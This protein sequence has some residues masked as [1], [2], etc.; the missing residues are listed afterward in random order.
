MLQEYWASTVIFIGI[1]SQCTFFKF[2]L[3]SL[4]C[5]QIQSYIDQW[6]S[7]LN[8][9]EINS[10]VQISWDFDFFEDLL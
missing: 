9:A 5:T 1:F 6:P 3:Y 2:E 8:L 4:N 10:S 7:V